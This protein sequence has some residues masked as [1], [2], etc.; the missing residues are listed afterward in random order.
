M[1]RVYKRVFFIIAILIVCV[2]AAGC[3]KSEADYQIDE[4]DFMTSLLQNVKFDC[5]LYQVKPESVENFFTLEEGTSAVVFM[6]SGSYADHAGIFTS[7]D[8]ESAAKTLEMVQTYVNDLRHSFEDYIPEEAA[9]IDGAVVEQKGKY[10]VLCISSDDGAKSFIQDYFDKARDGGSNGEKDGEPSEEKDGDGEGSSDGS[11]VSDGS[12]AQKGDG[13]N[14]SSD[15]EEASYPVIEKKGKVEEYGYVIAVGDTAY[16]LYS[17]SEKAGEKYAE[18]INKAA[19]SL[20]GKTKVYDVLIPL[21][22][23]ITLPDRLYGEISSSS[24]KKALQTL[25]E[26]MSKDVTVVNPYENLMKHRDEYIYFRTDH[27]WTADGAYYAYEELCKAAGILPVSRES[28]ESE[29]FEGFLGSFYKD[30]GESKKLKENPDTVRAYYP[31]SEETSLTY[32]TTDGKSNSWKVIWDV[33]DYGSSMKY[34][35][36][37][38]GDNPY[39]FIKNEALSDG[40][41]C[42]VVKESFG[43]AL[44]PFLV[45]HYEKIYVVD[46][47]YWEGDLTELAV[48]K[49]ADDLIFLNNLSMI[50]S[51]YLV[52][53]LAEII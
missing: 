40:S 30:T 12:A 41:C 17:Y 38:A 33:T 43:N 32:T 3:G 2:A 31:V 27:H 47:R 13:E 51:D 1:K 25:A 9:K 7:P 21:S 19:A 5:D 16:E 35:T 53:K 15:V 36:F 11:D 45:D 22:S 10:V 34:S 39:T 18:A 23:G 26:K 46:Y 6:G 52:G 50:R 42:V 24:Q 8:A 37:I 49:K 48:E 20:K 44:V 4:T 29:D 14:G 28:R